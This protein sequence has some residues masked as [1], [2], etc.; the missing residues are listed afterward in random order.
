MNYMTEVFHT[1]GSSPF[2]LL[3][4]YQARTYSLQSVQEAKKFQVQLKD[5]AGVKRGS[6]G[7]AD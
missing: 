1:T 4:M 7:Q 5:D 6:K 2:K 3:V